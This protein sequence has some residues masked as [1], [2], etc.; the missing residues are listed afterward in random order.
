MWV[1]GWMVTAG[2]CE[3]DGEEVQRR[4]VGSIQ[5]LMSAGG[6]SPTPP[7]FLSIAVLLFVLVPGVLRAHSER[8]LP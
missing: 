5:E 1:S 3:S 6:E 7:A 4:D 2:G 8:A